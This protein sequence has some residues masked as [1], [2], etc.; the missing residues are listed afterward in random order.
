MA[1]DAAPSAR[2]GDGAGPA[3]APP[4]A[5][6]ALKWDDALPPSLP[7]PTLA[8][9]ARGGLR[10]AAALAATGVCL[11]LY[12]LFRFIEKRIWSGFRWRE[13]VQRDWARAMA[14]LCGLRVRR[15]GVPMDHGGA[16]VA[17]HGSWSDIFVLVGTARMTFVSKDDV[18]GWPGVGWIAALCDTVFIERRR[19]AAKAQTEE[20]ARRMAGGERLLFFP[21]GTSTDGLRV[22]PF[23]S[24]LFGAFMD[25]TLRDGVWVQPV[26]VVYH[27]GPGLPRN[28]H[29]WWGDMEFGG[30]VW[31]VLCLSVGGS[32]E[33][34][35]HD[36]VRPR[37]FAD[38]KALAAHCWREVERG[39][40]ERL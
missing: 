36:P 28:F 29:G 4:S 27:P 20:M 21:E 18:R 33:V 19:G 39:V 40:V 14:R 25:E 35:F 10:L 2:L 11:M 30:A 17:N 16:L 7:D 13:R 34:V 1:E 15:V 8:E 23:R 22:L 32:A 9:R 38:R 31:D 6:D 24:T 12:M 26:S 37:D 3:P 5:A